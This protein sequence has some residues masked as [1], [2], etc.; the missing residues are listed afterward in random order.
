MTTVTRRPVRSLAGWDATGAWLAYTTADVMPLKDE[1]GYSMMLFADPLARDMLW[2]A[3]GDG[4][5]PGRIVASGLRT[6]FAHWSPRDKELSLWF[7]FSPTHRSL[8]SMGFGW[9][10]RSGDPAA[11]ID[12][13]TGRISWMAVT[14]NEKAQVGHYFLLK[15]NYAEA[16]R[17]YEEADR[18]R[19]AEPE[20]KP[21]ASGW[22]VFRARPFRETSLFEYYCL[23]KLGRHDEAQ[24]RLDTF[25]KKARQLLPSDEQLKQFMFGKP[26]EQ[27][28]QAV[29]EELH[30][31]T[32]L[33]RDCY[34]AEVF[35]SLDAAADGEQFFR[36]QMTKAVDGDDRFSAAIMLSQLL[37]LQGRTADYA[38]LILD[39]IAPALPK[40]GGVDPGL[41]DPQ[42]RPS[43]LVVVSALAPLGRD[44]LLA[45][46]PRGRLEALA[47][48][49]EEARA[50]A[51]HDAVRLVADL[52]LDQ[53]YRF[54]GRDKEMKAAR[55]RW[56]GN[57]MAQQLRVKV[58]SGD[59]YVKVRADAL[60]M[61]DELG[62]LLRF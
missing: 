20:P 41:D 29:N 5:D 50:K 17:W 56:Q 30:R 42:L 35:L 27:G 7:T 53:A 4:S 54:L 36:R 47:A 18:V 55:Q 6:T 44:D 57:P 43:L 28:D 46:V 25:R 11:T 51:G 1:R 48:Q 40:R 45:P 21:E 24:T 19:P 10:L 59:D 49:A 22:D 38:A 16:W 32:A 14:T 26:G 3:P 8:F 58:V 60:K 37:L 2:L 12:A 52:V 31:L 62:R 34:A 39:T 61:F 13:S 9:G 15:R 33:A 23:E